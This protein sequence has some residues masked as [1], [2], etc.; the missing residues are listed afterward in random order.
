MGLSGTRYFP[1]TYEIRA[2]LPGTATPL[3][4]PAIDTPLAVMENPSLYSVERTHI[5]WHGHSCLRSRRHRLVRRSV[6]RRF[7]SSAPAIRSPEPYLPPSR[8][9]T[10]LRPCP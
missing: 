9:L 6:P 10:S 5:V 4:E 1:P 3:N 2:P 7:P 8:A